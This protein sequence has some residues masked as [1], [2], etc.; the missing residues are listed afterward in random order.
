MALFSLFISCEGVGSFS[1]QCRAENPYDAIRSFIGTSQLNQF[2]SAHPD[3]PKDFKSRDIYAFI[4]LDGL[5]NLYFCGLGQKGK[6]V[7]VHLVQTVQRS[8]ATEKY[9]GPQRK[10]VTLR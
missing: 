6:Y 5:A 8:S 2:L 4:P 1:T 10:S 7:Q 3:W 9:C